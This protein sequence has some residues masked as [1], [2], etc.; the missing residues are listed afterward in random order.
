[1]VIARTAYI[2]SRFNSNTMGV[3]KYLSRINDNLWGLGVG[4]FLPLHPERMSMPITCVNKAKYKRHEFLFHICYGDENRD[5]IIA[6][7]LPSIQRFYS[8]VRVDELV[9]L[10]QDLTVNSD[11]W[12]NDK[13]RALFFLLL[14]VDIQLKTFVSNTSSEELLSDAMNLK[15]GIVKNT[16][17][18]E[19]CGSSQPSSEK[20]RSFFKILHAKIVPEW[21]QN[22]FCTY[23]DLSRE[24]QQ[25]YIVC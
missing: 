4:Y 19:M 24:I 14:N 5:Q 8:L 25:A 2:V 18:L 9:T 21:T 12:S 17:L 16:G 1:M 13:L 22:Q 23:S 15:G 11:K 7:I 3:K 6:L 20:L 10:A